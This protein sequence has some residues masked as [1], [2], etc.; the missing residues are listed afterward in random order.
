MDILALFVLSRLYG[1]HFRLF[2]EQGVWCSAHDRD[3]KKVSM[4]LI[5]R[6]ENRFSETCILNTTQDYL[7]S[8]IRNTQDDLMPS[9][10]KDQKVFGEPLMDQQE[11]L[12]ELDIEIIDDLCSEPTS[13]KRKVPVKQENIKTEVNIKTE[14]KSEFRPVGFSKPKNQGAAKY[15]R[16]LKALLKAKKEH[17]SLDIK[18]ESSQRRTQLIMSGNLRPAQI[19]DKACA[20]SNKRIVISCDFCPEVL[21]SGRKYIKH[22]KDCH[23]DK[24][25]YCKVCSKQYRSYNGCYKHER[26]HEAY[27]LFCGVCGKGFNYKK[28]L[29]MHIPVHSE[30]LKQFCAECSRGFASKR[31]LACHAAIHLNLRFDCQDC[32]KFYNTKEKLARHWQGNHG[33]GYT[34]LCGQFTYKWPGRRQK[35]QSECKE[36]GVQ[37]LLKQKRNFTG[38]NRTDLLSLSYVQTA[39]LFFCKFRSELSV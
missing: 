29:E 14:I 2:F 28:D 9:H 10:N 6:G 17:A 25:W 16:A 12:N 20:I 21:G 1:F 7:N 24:L 13:V 8:L 35:H 18:K 22:R 11:E 33:Q 36:C 32:P 19:A 27:K 15:N 31:T 30:D 26:T 37:K 39:L 38:L 5:F 4:M 34:T 3:F 23:P